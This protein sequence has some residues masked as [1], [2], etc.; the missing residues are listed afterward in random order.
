MN[1]EIK[2]RWIEKLRSGEY[3]Q[4]AEFLAKDGNFCCL[5]VLCEIAV[6]DGVV[7]RSTT[8]DYPD[9]DTVV[10]YIPPGQTEGHREYSTLPVA[11]MNWAGLDSTNPTV[12][13]PNTDDDDE[14][15]LNSWNISDVNDDLGRDFNEIA[16][17]IEEQL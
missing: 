17:I 8:E 16:D 4:G 7:V 6:E 13:L 5:G 2:A 15:E 14:E 10:A 11:V 9:E 12:V 1:T 3:N